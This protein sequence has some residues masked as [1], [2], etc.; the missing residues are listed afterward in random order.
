MS[1]KKHLRCI[2][3]GLVIIAAIYVMIAR[4][5]P[6][7][8]NSFYIGKYEMNVSHFQVT[9]ILYA[10]VTV[11]FLVMSFT[12][13]SVIVGT[14][15]AL[16]LIVLVGNYFYQ[17]MGM[18]YPIK[19]ICSGAFMLMGIVNLIYAIKCKC[20]NLKLMVVMAIGLIFAFLG[21]FAINQ[22]FVSGVV[23]F[24]LGHIFF[25]VTYLMYR[26]ITKIDV[27]ISVV[28]GILAV[29]FILFCPYFAF[30]PPVFQYICAA[31]ALIISV[32]VGKSLGNAIVEKSFYTIVIGI[33]SVLFFFSDV[34]LVLAWFSVLEGRWLSNLCMALYYPALVMLGWSMIIYINNCVIKK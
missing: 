6:E 18:A 27:A 4:I 17:D 8:T 23:F 21:D 26:K 28:W 9:Y 10:M 29:G 2:S 16:T 22:E 11:A 25:V 19:L 31:Y 13:L 14:N 7:I 5:F 12:K 1:S 33:A 30:D 20:K 15:I 24:A 3:L 34:A 32:M